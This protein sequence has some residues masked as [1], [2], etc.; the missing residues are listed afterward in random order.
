MPNHQDQGP[1]VDLLDGQPR[2][3]GQQPGADSK[4]YARLIYRRLLHRG[5]AMFGKNLSEIAIEAGRESLASTNGATVQ[6]ARL[7]WFPLG[8]SADF[9]YV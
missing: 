1:Q 7:A 5:S 6:I 2:F 3:G 8:R 9:S 4:K